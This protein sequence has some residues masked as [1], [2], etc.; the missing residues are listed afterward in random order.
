MNMIKADEEHF[1]KLYIYLDSE[2]ITKW[3]KEE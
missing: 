2:S 1:K 3:L